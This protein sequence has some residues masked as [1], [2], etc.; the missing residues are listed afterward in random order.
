LGA[1]LLYFLQRS[2]KSLEGGGG[3]R[4]TSFFSGEDIGNPSF[5]PCFWGDHSGKE[6]GKEVVTL[7]Q[8]GGERSVYF[9]LGKSSEEGAE[10]T[11]IGLKEKK[12]AN[13][14]YNDLSD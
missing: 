11:P 4:E 8:G 1:S 6:R 9:P 5:S 2:G 7:S 3:G 14:V 10:G 13:F 12:S